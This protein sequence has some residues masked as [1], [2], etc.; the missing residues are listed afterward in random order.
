MDN[1]KRPPV[2]IR[3]RFNYETGRIEEFTIDDQAAGASEDY[4]DRV[5]AKIAELLA[6]NPEIF[7]AGPRQKAEAL[8]AEQRRRQQ[9][10][11]AKVETG[12]D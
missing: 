10:T 5:A 2:R 9:A 11:D 6:R 8:I 1:S 7:D 12:S 4:H 3:F